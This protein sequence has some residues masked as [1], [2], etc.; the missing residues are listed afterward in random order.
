V[1]AN[2]AAFIRRPAF[3]FRSRKEN[4]FTEWL[5]S[6]TRYDDAAISN[7]TINAKIQYGNLVHVGDGCR[8]QLCIQN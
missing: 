7:A 8:Q 6:N 2:R 5:Q 1:W 3:D 4:D